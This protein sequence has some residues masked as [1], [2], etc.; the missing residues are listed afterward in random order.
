MPSNRIAPPRIRPGGLGTS[1]RIEAAVTL[2]PQPDSP[3]SPS[4]RPASI[5]NDTPSTARTSP[6]SVSNPTFRL[7]ISRSGT[8]DLGRQVGYWN[9]LPHVVEI[10]VDVLVD[11]IAPCSGAH[12]LFERGLRLRDRSR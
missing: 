6:A 5:V 7:S 12:G 9:R 3:T 1:R 8:C 2:L 4:V 10:L 11:R